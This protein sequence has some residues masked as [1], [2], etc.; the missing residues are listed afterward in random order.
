MKAFLNNLGRPAQLTLLLLLVILTGCATPYQPMSALGGYREI[1]LAPDV[2]RV[3]FFG[4]GYT[5][6]ELAIEYALHR[7]GELTEQNGY[8]YFGILSVEDLSTQSSVTIPG[9]ATTTGNL[10][11]NQ[12]GNMAFG[13]YTGRTFITPAQT[14]HFN[15]PRPVITVKMLNNQIPGATLFEAASVLSNRLPGVPAASTATS[16][17]TSPLPRPT[18]LQTLDD[19]QLK[20]RVISFVKE[21][22]AAGRSGSGLP[23]PASFYG[24]R[25]LFN[26]KDLSHEQMTQQ[27]DAADA[28]FPE[29]KSSF[30][31]E[32]VVIG[33]LENGER[34]VV[35]FKIAFDMRGKK[36]AQGKAAYQVTVQDG[37]SQLVVTAVNFQILEFHESS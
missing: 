20:A 6:P 11:V 30:I 1:Q 15:F 35:R 23:S 21:V 37:G 26:G 3:M 10:N 28:M 18:N 25:V 13:T 14:I 7:C 17:V 33:R 9:S 19:P 36:S 22:V 29:R 32:P 4:N 5:N 12:I 2:Y 27:I 24:S 34:I 8:Q 31:S 16:N